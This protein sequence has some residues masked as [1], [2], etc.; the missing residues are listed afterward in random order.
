MPKEEIKEAMKR[1]A[2]RRQGR[3]RLVYNK[4]K[5]TIVAVSSDGKETYTGLTIQEL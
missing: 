3:S 1:I 5:R 4:A 2:R